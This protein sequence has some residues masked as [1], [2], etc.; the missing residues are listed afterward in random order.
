MVLMKPK[1]EKISRSRSGLWAGQ[2]RE[3]EAQTYWTLVA[4]VKC[5][6]LRQLADGGENEKFE[7]EEKFALILAEPKTGRTHQIRVHFSA[8]NHPVVGDT[9]YAP[10]RPMALGFD[11][12]ALHS[13][14]IEFTNLSGEKVR[15]MA[16]L[17]HDFAAAVR[18]FDL[19]L[20]L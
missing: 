17:P 2:R 15:I 16:P 6:P 18:K 9:L 12:L 19:K 4:N 20:P 11:R 3:R 13:Y 8:V 1:A 10:R 14:S 7:T 5:N